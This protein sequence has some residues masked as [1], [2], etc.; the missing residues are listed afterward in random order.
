V[1]QKWCSYLEIYPS[2]KKYYNVMPQSPELGAKEITPFKVENRLCCIYPVSKLG[3]ASFRLSFCL[4]KIQLPEIRFDKNDRIISS[5]SLR[6][7]DMRP[8][9]PWI[10]K[11]KKGIMFTSEVLNYSIDLKSER[12][13]KSNNLKRKGHER[14][15]D[16][17]QH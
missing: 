14:Y 7:I 17:E 2:F 13:K 3:S 6:D 9:A 1:Q 11:S 10:Q 15:R 8:S 4:P 12:S 16:I 5:I